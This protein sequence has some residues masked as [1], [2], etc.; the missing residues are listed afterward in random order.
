MAKYRKGSRERKGRCRTRTVQKGETGRKREE[1]RATYRHA[2]RRAFYISGRKINKGVGG[3]GVE[4]V[5]K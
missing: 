3:E 5:R 2:G 4:E 1:D